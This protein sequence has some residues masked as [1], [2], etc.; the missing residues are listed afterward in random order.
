MQSLRRYSWPGNIRELQNFIERWVILSTDARFNPPLTELQNKIEY[1]GSTAETLDKAEREHILKVLEQTRW[2]IGGP[3][4][5]AL[6]LGLKRTT[7]LSKMQRLGIS[8]AT[9]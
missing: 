3:H 8:R 1:R 6:R 4:G 7:L 9:A 5:A 2:V